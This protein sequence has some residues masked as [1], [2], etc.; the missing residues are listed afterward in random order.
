MLNHF[1]DTEI[2]EY[3]KD[4]SLIEAKIDETDAKIDSCQQEAEKES[5]RSV[6]SLLWDEEFKLRDKKLLLLEHQTSL[7]RKS[8]AQMRLIINFICFSNLLL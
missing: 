3:E 7:M 2:D 8:P 1:L 5:L 6:L 4:I